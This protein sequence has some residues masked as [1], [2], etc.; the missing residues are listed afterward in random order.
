[1][2]SRPR[3]IEAIG[4]PREYV[5]CLHRRGKLNR[6]GRGIY[7]LPNAD[8]T[9]RHSCAEVSKRIPEAVICLLSAL[10]FHEIKTQSPASAYSHKDRCARGTRTTLTS[11][12]SLVTRMP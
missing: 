12:A 5:V 11:F 2:V 6:L 7:T 9:E 10:A 8:V 1:M 3:D 4:L